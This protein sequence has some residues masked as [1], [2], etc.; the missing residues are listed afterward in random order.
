MWMHQF[1]GTVQPVLQAGS[2]SLATKCVS[3]NLKFACISKMHLSVGILLESQGI[4]PYFPLL[5]A[6]LQCQIYCTPFT[7]TSLAADVWQAGDVALSLNQMCGLKSNILAFWTTGNSPNTRWA[8]GHLAKRT[9]RQR[10][11]NWPLRLPIPRAQT[12]VPALLTRTSA[13]SKAYPGTHS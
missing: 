12:L 10:R 13:R 5:S 3:S 7:G 1:K 2:S 9:Q 6:N 11:N 4:N 8:P